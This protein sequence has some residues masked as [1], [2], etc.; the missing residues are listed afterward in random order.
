MNTLSEVSLENFRTVLTTKNVRSFQFMQ[1]VYIPIILV[2]LFQ[3]WLS[4]DMAKPPKYPTMVIALAEKMSL[5]HIIIFIVALIL[6]KLL[7]DNKFSDANLI[8]MVTRVIKTKSGIV[9]LTSAERCLRVIRL[10]IQTRSLLFMAAAITGIV[11]TRVIIDKGGLFI[12]TIYLYNLLSSIFMFV[13]I[14]LRFPTRERLE[15]IFITRIQK[16]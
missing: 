13:Y 10:A 8:K 3:V 12:D 16:K 7:Y 5:I 2:F 6:S 9:Q 4:Y 15:N 1:L 11:L 14:G